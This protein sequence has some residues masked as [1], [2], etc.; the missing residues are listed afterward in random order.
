MRRK[1]PRQPMP[2]PLSMEAAE[3]LRKCFA[4]SGLLEELQESVL[5]ICQID[6][7]MGYEEGTEYIEPW[8][9]PEGDSM[10]WEGNANLIRPD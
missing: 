8:D 7:S 9:L 5:P 4:P 6:A 10:S 3:G 1:E 2:C